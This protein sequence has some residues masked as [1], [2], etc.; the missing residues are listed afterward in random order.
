MRR[1]KIASPRSTIESKENVFMARVLAFITLA[2][3]VNF[4][5]IGVLIP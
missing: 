4:A 5:I 2:I 3:G 1:R